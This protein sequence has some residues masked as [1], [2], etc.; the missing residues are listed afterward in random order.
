[1]RY[2]IDAYGHRVTPGAPE[3]G[4]PALIFLGASFTFGHGVE[5]DETYPALLQQRWPDL[6]IVNGATN[7]WGTTQ[8]LLSL[9]EHFEREPRIAG[10]VYAFI[11]NHLVRNHRRK[12]W[13]Y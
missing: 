6:R 10:V 1:M 7:G 13:E 11:T 5:D 8:A 12:Q 2:R 3:P 9:D 4:A